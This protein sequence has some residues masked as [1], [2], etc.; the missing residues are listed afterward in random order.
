[1]PQSGQKNKNKPSNTYSLHDVVQ[2]SPLSSSRTFLSHQKGDPL[3]IKQSFF[4]PVLSPSSWLLLICLSLW[5]CLVLIVHI[6]GTIQ[7]V[8]FSMWLLSL[9]IMSF[10][11]IPG[12]TCIST[13]FLS[14]WPK[15]IPFYGQRTVPH[16]LS[17]HQWMDIWVVSILPFSYSELCCYEDL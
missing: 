5:I 15:S 6:N 10:R 3:P 4:I 2:P 7:Y 8:D 16:Y 14:L 13:L 11:F 17:T 12:V 9:C 1:M